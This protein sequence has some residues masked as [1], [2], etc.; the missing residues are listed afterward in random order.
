MWTHFELNEYPW[1]GNYRPRTTAALRRTDR[2]FEVVM[3]CFEQHPRAVHTTP[4]S[5]V[6]QDS[7][8]EWFLS[9]DLHAGYLN[10]E[11]N[12][13]GALHCAFGKDRSHRT[14]VAQMGILRPTAEVRRGENFW[15]VRFTVMEETLAALFPRYDGSIL[16]GNFYKCGDCTEHPHFGAYAPI[17]LPTPNFHCPTFFVPIYQVSNK[18]NSRILL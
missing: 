3:T 17:A 2:G 12:A 14:F 13:N 8:M 9:G 5:D 18:T 15:E 1:G 4:D 7:C 11:C 6:Y 10:L 16:L